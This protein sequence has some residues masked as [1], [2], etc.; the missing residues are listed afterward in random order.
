MYK[1]HYRMY[2]KFAN[3]N[4]KWNSIML[5]VEEKN[6]SWNALCFYLPYLRQMIN[7]KP[8]IYYENGFKEWAKLQHL[9]LRIVAL[10]FSHPN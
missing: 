4:L 2:L 10:I 9:N 7:S 1:N 5:I 8:L 3:K 6:L